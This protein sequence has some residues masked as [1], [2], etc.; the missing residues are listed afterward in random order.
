M[1]RG[2]QV[3]LV[4]DRAGIAEAG[5]GTAHTIAMPEVPDL[6]API[7]YAVPAQL[8]AYHTAVAKGTDVDQPRNLAKSV[9]VE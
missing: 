9:T 8:L 3:V 7:V 6:L 2:G 1:A 4:T 5:D